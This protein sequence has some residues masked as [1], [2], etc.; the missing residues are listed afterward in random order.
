[1]ATY[2]EPLTTAENEIHER[3]GDPRLWKLFDFYYDET[4]PIV[5]R[6]NGCESFASSLLLGYG[7]AWALAAHCLVL[8]LLLL[9]ILAVLPDDV[10]WETRASNPVREEVEASS[11]M[12]GCF[13]GG[14][15]MFGSIVEALSR[16]DAAVWVSQFRNYSHKRYRIIGRTI[17][18]SRPPSGSIFARTLR[19]I[20]GFRS[21]PAFAERE[22]FMAYER[23]L[24]RGCCYPTTRIHMVY[25]VLFIGW[26]DS[27]VNMRGGSYKQFVVANFHY[28]SNFSTALW[29]SLILY[30]I[31]YNVI[32]VIT[33]CYREVGRSAPRF[34]FL[35]EGRQFV[36][37]IGFA[38]LVGKCLCKYSVP[39]TFRWLA[40][41]RAPEASNVDN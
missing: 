14:V 32:L 11:Y 29:V 21:H 4:V 30:A 27:M 20:Y 19:F 12:I 38:I 3:H 41:S 17:Y 15:T 35:P 2:A 36:S 16:L 6:C 5:R 10:V 40:R 8:E 33:D 31:L 13:A 7:G 24:R 39:V 28:V 34:P 22:E 37:D 23:A 26:V 9:G 25:A 18:I 1:M